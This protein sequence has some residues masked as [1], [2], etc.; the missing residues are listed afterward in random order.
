MGL[1]VQ[2]LTY[3]SDMNEA[4]THAPAPDYPSR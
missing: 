2:L 3:E 1:G 4:K